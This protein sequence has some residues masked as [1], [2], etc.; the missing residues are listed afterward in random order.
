MKPEDFSYLAELV[1]RRSGLALPAHKAPFIESRLA[2]VM[3][4]FGFRST[5]ALINELRHGHD[6]LARAVSEAMTTNES[7]FFRDKATFDK[8][9]DVVLPPLISARASSK[10]LRIWCAACAAGQ[11]AYSIAMILSDLKLPAKRWSI[12][13]FATDLSAEMIARAE[14]GVYPLYEVQRGLATRKLAAHF[15]QEGTSWRVHENLR[16]M[17]TFR[18][19]NLLDSY[20]WLDDLDVVFCRNVLLYFDRRTKVSVLERIAEI[21][22]PD[23]TLLLGHTETPDIVPKTFAPLARAPEFYVRARQPV[24]RLA[25]VG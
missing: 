17:I 20:G 8:F 3:R 10:R 19:F 11:E 9:R 23:G 5:S 15:T 25:S 1:R 7:S 22:A 4:R 6:A 18:Q 16:R 24:L 21:L 12:D 13:L 14:L 2:S